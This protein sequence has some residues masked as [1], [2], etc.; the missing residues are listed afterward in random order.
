[1]NFQLPYVLKCGGIE[2]HLNLTR[3][4]LDY[5]CMQ[6]V[7]N[8]LLIV[9]ALLW[10]LLCNKCCNV[11][12]EIVLWIVVWK[13]SSFIC[14]NTQYKFAMFF[15]VNDA[16]DMLLYVYIIYVLQLLKVHIYLHEYVILCVYVVQCSLSNALDVK[17]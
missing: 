17:S 5:C 10:R 9:V 6:S 3:F 2:L 15:C 7:C 14:E 13:S 4:V 11:V 16:V 8:L 1:M 12:A